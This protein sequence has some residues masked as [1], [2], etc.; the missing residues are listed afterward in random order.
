MNMQ[1]YLQNESYHKILILLRLKL[2]ALPALLSFSYHELSYRTR[3]CQA[4][5]QIF[6]VFVSWHL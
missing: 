6:H 5:E 4:I 1:V 2:Q 3:T